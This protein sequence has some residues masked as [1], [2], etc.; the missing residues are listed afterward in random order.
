MKFGPML[1]TGTALLSA[2]AHG[3]IPSQERERTLLIG[4]TG[5]FGQLRVT[6]QQIVEDSRCPANVQCIQAGTV[7]VR[8]LVEPPLTGA[9][10]LMELGKPQLISGG[11]LLLA[12]VRPRR[13]AGANVAPSDYRLVF[14]Y[15]HPARN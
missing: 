15:T 11:T 1:L 2:C 14:R 13:I 4:Q 9:P 7:R 5:D 10:R 8:A 3:D 12:E 6:P